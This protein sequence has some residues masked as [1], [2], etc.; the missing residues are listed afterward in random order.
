MASPWPGSANDPE[1]GCAEPSAPPQSARG[2]AGKWTGL[3]AGSEKP[4][5]IISDDVSGKVSLVTDG[6]FSAL[7]GGS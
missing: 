6:I 1:A 3:V 4:R 2:G 5:F 7:H